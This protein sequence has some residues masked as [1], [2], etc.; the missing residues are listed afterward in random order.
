MIVPLIST[1]NNVP[2]TF[3][4]PPVSRVPPITT[5]AMAKAGDDPLVVV[6]G[7]LYL[8]GEALSGSAWARRA[9]PTKVA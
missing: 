5:E 2:I 8:V 6:A 9:W 4:T 7:S 1:P 3:P